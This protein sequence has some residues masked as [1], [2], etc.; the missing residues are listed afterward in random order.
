MGQKYRISEF[1]K[2]IGRTP[3]T[4][5]R[6]EQEGKIQSKRL[7]SGHRYF[8]ESDI[9]LLLGGPTPRRLIVVYCRVSSTGQKDHLAAQVE[10]MEAFCQAAG[11]GVDEWVQEI[12]GGMNFKRKKFLAL[13]SDSARRNSQVDCSTQRSIDEIWIRSFSAYR[14]R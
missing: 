13:G 9:R 11:I 7:P 14:C 10:A 3:K 4:V 6:W 2:R 5:R 12:G 1:A 8:D